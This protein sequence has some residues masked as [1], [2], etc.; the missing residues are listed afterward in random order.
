[1]RKFVPDTAPVTVLAKRPPP[2]EIVSVTTLIACGGQR[3][4]IDG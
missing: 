1:M 3:Y 4:E 2:G